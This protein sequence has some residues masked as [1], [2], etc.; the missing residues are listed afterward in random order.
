VQQCRRHGVGIG[1]V[2]DHVGHPSYV[3]D[4]ANT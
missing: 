4:E 3:V 1:V 2:L